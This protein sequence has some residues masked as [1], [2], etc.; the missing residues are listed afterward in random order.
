MNPSDIDSVLEEVKL[1]PSEELESE[2]LEFKGYK[3]EKAL[4][5]ASDLPEE[6]SALGNYRGGT[7]IVGVKDS[8]DV[9][10][11]KW[12][13][14]L[15]GIKGVD[16]ISAGERI[17]GKI[18]P[19][20]IISTTI[21][22]FE[23][24]KYLIIN[25]EIPG[26]S[27]VS[28]SGGKYYI[29]DGRSKCPMSPDEVEA[30]IK[31]L[32]KYDWSA[33]ILDVDS[34]SELDD[35]A[36]GDAMEDYK[37]RRDITERFEAKTYLEA[38]GA[39]NNGK[40]TKGGLLFL[41][42]SDSILHYLGNYEYRFTWKD[43]KGNLQANDVWHGSLWDA[44]RKMKDHF[45]GCN[46]NVV[47]KYRGRQF[48]VPKMDSIAFHEALLNGL[49]HRSYE[50]DGM[51]A[52]EYLGS[53]IRITSPGQF[54][55]GITVDNIFRHQP[56]HRNK[57]LAKILMSHHYIDRAGMG[58]LRMSKG[59]L[60]YGR[61]FP[62]FQEEFETVQV[63]LDATF[64]RP[65]ITIITQE[66]PED[67]SIEQLLILNSVFGR[68]YENVSVVEEKLKR[69]YDDPWEK[70][71]QAVKGLEQVEI[72]GTN[73]GVFIRVRPELKRIFDVDR[74]FKASRASEKH[75]K[76]YDHLQKY[77]EASNAE[78]TE[79]LGHTSGAHTSQFLR[80]ARYVEREGKGPSS[81]WRFKE[82][83]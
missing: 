21:H 45:N 57:V 71:K 22:T 78:I 73:E 69:I 59:S 82:G 27:L 33:D 11:S 50:S 10:H 30:A 65:G 80:N 52:A 40:V 2:T 39:T 60:V 42:R 32:T 79:S 23:G 8:S 56:R 53:S 15:A 55:G 67:F 1:T 31:S 76:L 49:V 54:Y 64:L 46:K 25:V 44:I 5:N 83:E 70:I 63:T 47:F 61:A 51:I 77:G 20:R 14:Q 72:C 34:L 81:R 29:R 36:V 13:D 75:I 58:V 19:K 38:I 37:R 35:I 48:E 12:W 62:K 74:V 41:G 6:I 66:S 17:R 24:K 4:H 7:I 43:D 16:P 18:L 26:D 3:N 68:G 9:R 28:T